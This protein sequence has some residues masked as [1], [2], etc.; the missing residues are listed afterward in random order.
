MGRLL[1]LLLLILLALVSAAGYIFIDQSII[2]GNIKIA[3]G[4]RELELGHPELEKGRVRMEAGRQELMEG[5]ERYDQ[6][7]KNYFLVLADKLLKGG[8]GFRDARKRI[9]EGLERISMGEVEFKAG[10]KRIYEGEKELLRG[11]ELMKQAEK[12]R[13]AFGIAAAFFFILAVLS[14]FRWRRHLLR[15]FKHSENN[16]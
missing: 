9:E 10:K 12:M 16:H 4:I 15:L 1:V 5:Q 3:E 8:E 13:T 11:R 14:G 6:A 7:R 2:A